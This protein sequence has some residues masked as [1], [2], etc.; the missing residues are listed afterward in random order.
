MSTI[1]DSY[2]DLDKSMRELKSE[3]SAI[4][5]QWAFMHA[6]E[7]GLDASGIMT[8]FEY[9]GGDNVNVSMWHYG[10]DSITVSVPVKEL[11]AFDF[12]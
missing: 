9:H 4:C 1:F 8:A 12:N 6:Y 3:I 2:L 10:K 7:F 5:T 11:L